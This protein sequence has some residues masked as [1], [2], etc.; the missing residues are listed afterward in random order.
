MVHKEINQMS[1]QHINIPGTTIGL[2]NTN[3]PVIVTSL[4][5]KN[6]ENKEKITLQI[7]EQ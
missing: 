3:M 2:P 7:L 1:V 5:N 6:S 4:T